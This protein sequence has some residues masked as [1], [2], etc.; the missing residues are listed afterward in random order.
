[1]RQG[2]ANFFISDDNFARN[3]SWEAI[4]DRLIRDAIARRRDITGTDARRLVFS[5]ADGLPGLIVD[6]YAEH[7]VMQ[8]RTA[9]GVT[10]YPMA[11]LSPL[12][13]PSLRIGMGALAPSWAARITLLPKARTDG[14]YGIHLSTERAL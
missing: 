6:Q 13:A 2:V 9:G 7:L 4:L 3:R 12:L 8:L 11:K 1:M 10:G 5:E 14:S